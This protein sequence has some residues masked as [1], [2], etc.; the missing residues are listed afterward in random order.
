VLSIF[1]G[2]RLFLFLEGCFDIIYQVRP[3]SVILQNVVAIAMVLVFVVLIPIMVLVSSLPAL[4]VAMLQH[5]PLGHLPGSGLLLSLSGIMGGLLVAYLLFQTIY[6]VVP[7]RRISFRKSWRGAVVAAVLLELYLV[8]FP[9][10]VTYFLSGL[11]AAVG[12]LILL[13]FFY[14]FALI[15]FLGAEVNAFLAEGIHHMPYDLATMVHLMTSQ[16]ATDAND[17][18]E[19]AAHAQREEEAQNI[20]P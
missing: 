10:Y 17:M 16:L 4:A 13:L 18:K 1:N 14:Y 3:R 8:L 2:S 12:L 20:S 15:I 11:A 5:T 6:L 19:Q 9:L 7:H